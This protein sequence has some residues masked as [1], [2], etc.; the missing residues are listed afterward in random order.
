MT[1][2]V[3]KLQRACLRDPVKVEVAQ[4]YS[5]VDTL[6]QQYIFLPAKHKVQIIDIKPPQY[7][8]IEVLLEGKYPKRNS[9]RKGRDRIFSTEVKPK[10]KRGSTT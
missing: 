7:D 2:M 6:R 10:R 8:L 4:K 5:T 1:T 9:A 3:A